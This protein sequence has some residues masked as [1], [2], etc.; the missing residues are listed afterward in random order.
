LASDRLR[1]VAR[2][3]LCVSDHLAV[4][5]SDVAMK[6]PQEAVVDCQRASHL[7]APRIMGSGVDTHQGRNIGKCQLANPD[8]ALLARLSQLSL[9]SA[10]PTTSVRAL[11]ASRML[12]MSVASRSASNGALVLQ[13][14]KGAKVLLE[15]RR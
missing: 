4:E 7:L 2:D 9:A 5:E 8:T 12:A 11:N 14:Y 1:L 6:W 13:R 10:H 15:K 3:P